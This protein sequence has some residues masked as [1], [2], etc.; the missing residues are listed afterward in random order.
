MSAGIHTAFQLLVAEIRKSVQFV[1][2]STS[3]NFLLFDTRNPFSLTSKDAPI[4][5]VSIVQCGSL[6][7]I[8]QPF[9]IWYKGSLCNIT[10]FANKLALQ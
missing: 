9:F 6:S 1:R 2:H 5:H 7:L 4:W 3:D 8:S 10:C